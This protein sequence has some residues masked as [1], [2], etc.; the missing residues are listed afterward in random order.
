MA[1]FYLDAETSL[2]P[3]FSD[4]FFDFPK[5]NPVLEL[6]NQTIQKSNLR[7]NLQDNFGLIKKLGT[8][9]TILANK[10]LLYDIQKNFKNH[11]KDYQKTIGK[12]PILNT[13]SIRS[14]KSTKAPSY[15]NVA[16]N[17]VNST[18]IQYN[19]EN[20]LDDI[21]GSVSQ[22][23]F[24]EIIFSETQRVKK[25]ISDIYFNNQDLYN[26]N[27]RDFEI[28]I[29][30]LL[31]SQG[32]D[33]ELTQQTR[34]GGKDIIA[35]KPQGPLLRPI[36]YLVE[37]KKYAETNK[38]DVQIMRS[39]SYVVQQSANKGI[40][41]TTSY[42]TKDVQKQHDPQLLDLI[43]KNALLQWIHIYILQLKGIL[44]I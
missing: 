35:I 12:S 25:V 8:V 43:D 3:I 18:E 39:F 11:I 1:H 5:Q 29:A 21:E 28:M 7:E 22:D 17:E 31:S 4:F 16:K 2:N 36:K 26:L 20:I 41:V 42:F 32:F 6:Y 30:E 15:I 23:L 33:V 19:L 37:C 24:K 13:L 38:V 40:L 44:A 10:I 14:N 9:D 27:P 34:D